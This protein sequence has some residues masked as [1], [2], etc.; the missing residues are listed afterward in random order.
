[1][2]EKSKAIFWFESML[3]TPKTPDNFVGVCVCV[4]RSNF[5]LSYSY[6]FY[7]DLKRKH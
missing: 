4:I 2:S 3:T 7:L 6:I 5:Y 1:M